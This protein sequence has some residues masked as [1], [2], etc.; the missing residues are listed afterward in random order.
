M[1]L[2]YVTFRGP[3]LNIDHWRAEWFSRNLLQGI[4]DWCNWSILDIGGYQNVSVSQSSGLY[5]GHMAR[6][7]PVQ[8]PNY[9]DGQVWESARSDWVWESGITYSGDAPTIASGVYISG[10]FYPT[11]TTGIGAHH[12]NFP[13]GR[14][15]FNS[16]I[17]VSS[18]VQTNYSYRTV[19]FVQSKLPW[20]TQ[21]L[22]N[23]FKIER[24]DFLSATGAWSHLSQARRQMP[25]VGI[26][27]V[28]RKSSYPYEMG[29]LA[30]Y[31]SQ[32]ILMYI[33]AE[34]DFDR[35]QIVDILAGQNDKRIWLPDR[36]RMKADARYPLDLD[37]K[38]SPVDS[39]MYYPDIIDNFPWTMVS[40]TNVSIQ[41]TK[42]INGWLYS[43]IARITFNG[44]V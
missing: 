42:T 8:D 35:D 25:V 33:F 29:S 9:T 10:V 30:Q 20:F 14:V 3:N 12:I 21:F 28:N 17:N 13:L 24:A 27:L 39:P 44:I 36:A 26:E 1:S 15:V 4:I 6:L 2:N 43:A 23:S 7:R 22:Y 40:I 19:S 5:G 37:Y 11:S 18:L 16:P 38:G 34:N 31:M 41:S 32:D